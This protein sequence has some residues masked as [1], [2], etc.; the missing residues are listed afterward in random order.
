MVILLPAERKSLYF[1]ITWAIEHVKHE[2]LD[3][4]WLTGMPQKTPTS[5]LTSLRENEFA[6]S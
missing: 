5:E 3:F 6:E 2:E 4:L 1:I